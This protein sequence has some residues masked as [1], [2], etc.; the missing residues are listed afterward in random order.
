MPYGE[1]NMSSSPR[2]KIAD[3]VILL[4]TVAMMGAP[5]VVGQHVSDM[6]GQGLFWGGLALLLLYIVVRIRPWLF[7]TTASEGAGALDNRGG[8][9]VGGDNTGTQ[10]VF[11]AP[12]TFHGTPNPLPQHPLQGPF[13]K[14]ESPPSTPQLKQPVMPV[15]NTPRTATQP[16]GMPSPYDSPIKWVHAYLVN[17][18]KIGKDG[19]QKIWDSLRQ[20][21]RDG[22]IT[23]WGR[24]DSTL[25]HDGRFYKPIEAIPP[26]HW[27]D[28]GF[29]VLRCLFDEDDSNC[30]TEPD[31]SHGLGH[32]KAYVDLHV[33]AT[34]VRATWPSAPTNQDSIELEITLR[35]EIAYYDGL[36]DINSNRIAPGRA[37]VAKIS[38]NSKK[39][40]T[41]CQV[42]F[43]AGDSSYFVSPPFD[44]RIGEHRDVMVLLLRKEGQVEHPLVPWY[45]EKNGKW[46]IG[47]GGW[48]PAPGGYQITVL[49]DSAAPAL[50]NVDLT[51]PDKWA[52]RS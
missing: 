18:A 15:G 38:N 25:I 29:D 5:S 32:D 11:N 33:N 6:V 12:V 1:D 30:K 22:A 50:L 34:Q 43:G 3:G 47:E 36:I 27:R 35:H 39:L 42:R 48:V 10:N 44:L 9:H 26:E 7:G 31:N 21:A 14:P 16:V 28:F 23:V 8:A 37:F 41:K 4:A 40:L 19:D 24:P 51:G 17:E 49:S 52:L 46:G 45:E 13:Q 2:P 20:A